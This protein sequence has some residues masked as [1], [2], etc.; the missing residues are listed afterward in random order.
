MR[1][2]LRR[3]GKAIVA[4]G[5]LGSWSVTAGADLIQP[6]R[7]LGTINNKYEIVMDLTIEPGGAVKGSYFYKTQK[8][9]I[10]LAGTRSGPHIRLE[11]RDAHGIRTAQFEGDVIADGKG[12]QGNWSTADGKTRL[13]FV[14]RSA[15]AVNRRILLTDT[16]TV[17]SGKIWKIEGIRLLDR[18]TVAAADLIIDGQAFKGMKKAYSLAGKFEISVNRH[19][20]DPLWILAGSRVSIVH[21]AQ[22]IFAEELDS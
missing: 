10:E 2:S 4:V 1:A 18:G 7:Y 11:E 17:A 12:I 5:V 21:T 3:Y 19:Q 14:L 6:G 15:A 9:N 13:P 20:E 8:K 16:H 22:Q